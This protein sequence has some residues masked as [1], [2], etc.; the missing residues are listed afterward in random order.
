MNQITSDGDDC[1]LDGAADD[2][3]KVGPMNRLIRRINHAHIKPLHEKSANHE[4][5]LETMEKVFIKADGAL[6]VVK[7]VAILVV[8]SFMG[9]AV[10]AFNLWQKI[11]NI[12]KVV[13]DDARRTQQNMQ[14]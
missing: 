8:G 5:R 3:V 7:L 13:H 12:P 4:Q 1:G 10:F 14:R 11:E 6:L 2:P 9:G